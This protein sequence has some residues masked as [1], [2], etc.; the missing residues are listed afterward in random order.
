MCGYDG[1]ERPALL[2]VDHR[3]LRRQTK[4]KPKAQSP[5][6]SGGRPPPFRPNAAVQTAGRVVLILISSADRLRFVMA[7]CANSEPEAPLRPGTPHLPAG[8]PRPRRASR[9]KAGPAARRGA[10]I[11]AESLCHAPN[12]RPSWPRS[13]ALVVYPQASARPHLLASPVPGLLRVRCPGQSGK[14]KASAAPRPCFGN[15]SVSRIARPELTLAA[16]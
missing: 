8:G 10:R 16:A 3:C 14:R 5:E 13:G 11:R 2:R 7:P 4:L 9:Q 15:R 6:N 12:P 1:A